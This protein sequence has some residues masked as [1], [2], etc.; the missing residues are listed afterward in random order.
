MFDDL[1]EIDWGDIG[2]WPKWV[3]F[4]GAGIICVAILAATYWFQVR[5]QVEILAGVERQEVQLKNEFKEKKALAI[6][7]EAYRLQMVEAEQT[8]SVLKEQLPSQNEIPDLLVDVTQAGLSRGLKFEQFKPAVAASE[9]FYTVKPVN[10]IVN[11]SYHQLAQFVSD[12][13]ALPR[14]VNV[15]NFKISR[16]DEGDLRMSAITKTYYYEEDGGAAK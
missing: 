14:I 4:T 9:G 10:I 6:N 5:K 13:A 3:K 8:F 15:D 12:V 7:L 16:R 2:F 11:G 1:Q